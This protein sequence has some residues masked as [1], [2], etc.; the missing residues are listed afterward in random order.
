MKPHTNIN[1]T[2]INPNKH[3]NGIFVTNITK[4]STTLGFINIYNLQ[5]GGIYEIVSHTF[6][7]FHKDTEQFY[8]NL[9]ISF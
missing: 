5:L 7:I 3:H 6:L 1:T 9:F 2:K 8:I 4:A